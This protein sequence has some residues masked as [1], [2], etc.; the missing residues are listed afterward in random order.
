MKG[1][2]AEHFDA[3]LRLANSQQG[4]SLQR[5]PIDLMMNVRR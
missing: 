2:E 1:F 5:R 3:Y 4:E